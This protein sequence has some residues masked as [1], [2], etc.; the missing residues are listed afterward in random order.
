MAPLDEPLKVD[1][2]SA[3]VEDSAQNNQ[4]IAPAEVSNSVEA[5]P[6]VKKEEV[7][8]QTLLQVGEVSKDPPCLNGRK[9]DYE[10]FCN[11]NSAVN[12]FS[13]SNSIDAIGEENGHEPSL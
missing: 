9:R 12:N 2:E 6:A 3:D 7:T 10:N 8:S 5:I 1:K 11:G 13:G 4:I